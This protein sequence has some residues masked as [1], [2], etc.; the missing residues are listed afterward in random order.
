MTS[1]GKH[2]FTVD[3]NG[4]AADL[5]AV[6]LVLGV[7]QG[8][9]GRL[10]GRPQGQQQTADVGR[11][12]QRHLQ[13]VA[14]RQQLLEPGQ[15]RRRQVHV[16]EPASVKSVKEVR[17]LACF[18]FWNFPKFYRILLGFT[19]FRLVLQVF[20]GFHLVLQEFTGIYWVLLGFIGFYWVLTLFNWVLIGFIEFY[21]V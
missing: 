21:R 6:A 4:W 9:D 20:T 10:G 16:K 15:Q 3:G 12:V 1:S 5:V 2:R 7:Q 8:H 14:L 13:R 17:L 19:G 11:L 18:F